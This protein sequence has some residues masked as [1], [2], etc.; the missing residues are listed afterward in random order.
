MIDIPGIKASAHYAGPVVHPD[1]RPLSAGGTQAGVVDAAAEAAAAAQVEAVIA[2]TSR[3]IA[4]TFP[5]VEHT[6][7]VT[8]SCLYTT[9]ADHDYIISRVPS[10]PNVVL[11]GGGSGHAFKMGPAI[12]EGAAAL[13]LSD[14]PPPYPMEQFDLRRLLNLTA[15]SADHEANAPR[16]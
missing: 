13:A 15:D 10:M 2:S 1:R 6:P 12:G 4:R 8:Q 16:K 5:H 11:A 3:F 14:R 9:T 7:F